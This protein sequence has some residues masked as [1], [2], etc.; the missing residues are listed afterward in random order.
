[1]RELTAVNDKK[2]TVS[3]IPWQTC[4]TFTTKLRYN[5]RK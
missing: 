5:F 3:T 4:A 1:M 2:M